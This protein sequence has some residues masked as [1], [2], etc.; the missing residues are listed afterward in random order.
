MVVARR[1]EQN[2]GQSEEA[3]TDPRLRAIP[4]ELHRQIIFPKNVTLI[5]LLPLIKI[6]QQLLK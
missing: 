1:P 4:P 2:A 5:F 3:P 6:R